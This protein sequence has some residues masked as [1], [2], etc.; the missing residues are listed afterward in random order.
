MKK[1]LITLL[2][3]DDPGCASR[4]PGYNG[5]ALDPHYSVSAVRIHDPNFRS[6]SFINRT[7]AILPKRRLRSIYRLIG[8][9]LNEK[10]TT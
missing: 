8:E 1:I 4:R 6:L 5:V 10:D 2:L 7:I 3:E 9:Y